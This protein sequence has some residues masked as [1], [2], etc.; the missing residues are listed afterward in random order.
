MFIIVEGL[1]RKAYW[2]DFEAKFVIFGGFLGGNISD[3][4]VAG[5]GGCNFNY[6][7][8]VLSVTAAVGDH[9]EGFVGAGKLCVAGTSEL[10]VCGMVFAVVGDGLTGVGR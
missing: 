8:T 3:R 4:H 9:S 7:F 5:F 1:C 10:D 2:R 6:G